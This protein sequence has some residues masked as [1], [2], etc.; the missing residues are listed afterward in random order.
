[1]WKESAAVTEGRIFRS[2]KKATVIGEGIADEKAIWRL[3]V[4]YAELTSLE[5][6]A[7]HDLRR[8]CAKLCHQAGGLPDQTSASSQ[9]FFHRSRAYF[10]RFGFGIRRVL[11]DNGS[12]YRDGHFKMLLNRQ[13]IRQRFTRPYTPRTNGKAERFIQTAL[14]EWA[15]A[16]PIKTQQNERSN[17]TSGSSASRSTTT[18]ST[19]HMLASTSTRPSA[20]QASIGTTS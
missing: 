2:V 3:V 14:R 9:R 17:S 7:P 16:E 11:T 12:C 18:T 20:D 15:Y 1:M 10:S 8:T 6:L 5:K 13:H 4:A 19:A